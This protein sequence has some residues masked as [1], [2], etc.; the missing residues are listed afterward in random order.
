MTTIATLQL[1]SSEKIT[2]NLAIVSQLVAQANDAGASLVVLPEM[3]ALI[4]DNETLKH[5][6]QEVDGHGPIQDFLATLAQK[7]QLWLVAGTLPIAD[8]KSHKAYA[9]CLVYNDKG[10]R[11]ARYDKIHL[12]DVTLSGKESYC[13]SATTLPGHNI[14][15]VKTPFGKLGLSVCYD[16]RFP[17]L[18]NQL[19]RCGAE[20]IIIPAAFTVSTGEAHWHVLARCRAIE[21]FC[22]VIGA[23]QGG[24]HSSGRKTYGHSLIIDP[25]GRILCETINTKA[26]MIYTKIDLKQLHEMRTTIPTFEHQVIDNLSTIDRK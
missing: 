8:P 1:C 23:C 9:A 18:Y 25:W 20:I 4:E 6:A 12:F 16:I 10:Q 2:E 22:Y 7:H 14:V 11:M 15:V 26:S 5:Q 17:A 21:N 13:E 24:T 3:F 19:R